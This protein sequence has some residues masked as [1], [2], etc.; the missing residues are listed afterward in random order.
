MTATDPA[1]RGRLVDLSILTMTALGLAAAWAQV[2]AVDRAPEEL[3]VATTAPSAVA[4][5]SVGLQP[6]PAPRRVVVVRRS[7]A[8]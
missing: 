3:V 6:A 4:A 2:V 1:P 7:R 5:A 8:S